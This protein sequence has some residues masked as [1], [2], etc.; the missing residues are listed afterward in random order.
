MHKGRL[1]APFVFGGFPD[2]DRYGTIWR[3]FRHLAFLHFFQRLAVNTQSCR[4]AGFQA[5]DADFDTALVAEAVF[6]AFDATQRLVDLLDQLALAV[7]IAQLDG[8]IGFL[9][10]PVIRVGKD[11]GLVLHGVHGAVDILAEFL[12]ERLKN[13]AEMRE[14]LGAHVVFTRFGFV[15]R[16]MFVEQVFCHFLVRPGDEK[17]D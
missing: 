14:L 16:E 8:N 11:G 13:L 2:V 17:G 6:T 15:R 3:L 10:G 5:L 1:A 12:L 4:R 7:A 9:A